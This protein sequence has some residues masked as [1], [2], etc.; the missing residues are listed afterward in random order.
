MV[1]ELLIILRLGSGVAFFIF[2]GAAPGTLDQ[3]GGR[4]NCVSLGLLF[5]FCYF[6]E[7]EKGALQN[8]VVEICTV[9][10]LAF[11]VHILIKS[12]RNS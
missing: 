4:A 2:V 8:K 12:G 10:L 3:K 1:A 7:K 6:Y 11:M 5:M 9:G